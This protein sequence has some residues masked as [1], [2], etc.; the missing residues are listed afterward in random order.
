M[1][2][3]PLAFKTLF[4]STTGLSS[5]R[6]TRLCTLCVENASIENCV[7]NGI[8]IS[9]P[10]DTVHESYNPRSPLVNRSQVDSPTPQI[11]LS[12]SCNKMVLYLA[13]PVSTSSID[14]AASFIGLV[15]IH[16][17]TPFSTARS[18]IFKISVLHPI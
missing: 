13:L 10:D 7:R 17:L 9:I 2:S 18:S 6:L 16:G 15:V 5:E 1:A 3:F 11:S 4:Y 12:I 8:H 14:L